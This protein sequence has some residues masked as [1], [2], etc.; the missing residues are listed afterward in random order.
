MDIEM[1]F[2]CV[3]RV[4]ID[5]SRC[6]C[7]RSSDGNFQHIIFHNFASFSCKFHS[8]M[9]EISHCVGAGPVLA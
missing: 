4:T 9:P 7:H 8:D 2:S 1:T 6:L 3:L 5:F